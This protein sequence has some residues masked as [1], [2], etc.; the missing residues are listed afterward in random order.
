[1]NDRKDL[2][3]DDQRLRGGEVGEGDGD[4][5]EARRRRTVELT[6]KRCSMAESRMTAPTFTPFTARVSR[7]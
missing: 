1:V 6:G 7:E 2:C 3:G 4:A 5:D